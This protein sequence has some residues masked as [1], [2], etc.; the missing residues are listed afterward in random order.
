M[1]LMTDVFQAL[2]VVWL[3]DGNDDQKQEAL[4]VEP[5]FSYACVGINT[6]LHVSE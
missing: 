6:I 3:T 4:K 2:H 1:Y 5:V